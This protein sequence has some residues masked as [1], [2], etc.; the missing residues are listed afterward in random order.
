VSEA[1]AG[2]TARAVARILFQHDALRLR[3]AHRDGRWEQWNA[4]PE[5]LADSWVQVDLGSLPGPAQD[6]AVAAAARQ[7][8]GRDELEGPLARFVLFSLGSA[9]P[10]RL[11]VVLHHLVSDAASWR[12][13]R[14]D[15]E[16]ALGQALRG[17]EIELP[18]KTTSFRAWARRQADLA[19]SAEL[20][21]QVD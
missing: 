5:A 21:G 13:L 9:R 15:L 11:L 12:I 6:A 20:R 18:P 7:L 2:A 17:E 8:Q 4:G 19:R 16:T 14:E 10:P 1:V 3:V